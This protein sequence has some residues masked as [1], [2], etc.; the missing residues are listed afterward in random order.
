MSAFS[1]YPGDTPRLNGSVVDGSGSPY[2]LVGASIAFVGPGFEAQG[3][4][5]DAPNGLYYVDLQ[6]DQTS[7]LGSN[8]TYPFSIRLTRG[9]SVFTLLRSQF[10]TL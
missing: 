1:I 6:T 2:S 3:V 9:S 8:G 4:I 10:S 7:R 5:S